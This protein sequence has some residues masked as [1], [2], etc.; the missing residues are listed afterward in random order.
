M[1]QGSVIVAEILE[2]E[3]DATIHHW[4]AE[5]EKEPELSRI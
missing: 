2:R 1:K 4:M 3:L 5:V